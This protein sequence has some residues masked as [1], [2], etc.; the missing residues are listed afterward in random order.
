MNS[1]HISRDLSC[2]YNRDD[3][4]YSDYVRDDYHYV[5]QVYLM[6]SC[7]LPLLKESNLV[8][9][10]DPRRKAGLIINIGETVEINDTTVKRAEYPL[11]FPFHHG[12]AT[13]IHYDRSF[14]QNICEV[15]EMVLEEV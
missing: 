9:N 14:C 10:C 1:K 2:L 15:F 8:G 12:D 6:T 3:K 11:W 4:D 13:D 7:Q 5:F